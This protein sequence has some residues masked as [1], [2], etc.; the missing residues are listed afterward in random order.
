MLTKNIRQTRMM[1]W[2]EDLAV[3]ILA[4]EIQT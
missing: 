3:M 1:F 2:I 4:K